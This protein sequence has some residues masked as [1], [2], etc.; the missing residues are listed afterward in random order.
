MAVAYRDASLGDGEGELDA[1]EVAGGEQGAGLGQLRAEPLTAVL[2]HALQR[3]LLPHAVKNHLHGAGIIEAEQLRQ[4][5]A[6]GGGSHG[7]APRPLHVARCT[8]KAVDGVGPLLAGLGR[9]LGAVAV[10]VALGGGGFL[11]ATCSV[12]RGLT[13]ARGNGCGP[14]GAGGGPHGAL[15]LRGGRAAEHARG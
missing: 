7:L 2:G 10:A 9:A 8:H 4:G 3:A 11:D 5:S 12:L 13:Y 1:A 6:V 15:V 14:A